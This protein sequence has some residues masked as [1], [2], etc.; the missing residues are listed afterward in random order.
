[1]R[2]LSH[3]RVL[4]SDRFTSLRSALVRVALSSRQLFFSL[5]LSLSRVDVKSS[6]RER[7]SFL[8]LKLSLSLDV[9]E[10]SCA[11]LNSHFYFP[12]HTLKR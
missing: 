5:S 3:T 1:M 11:F 4:R 12:A 10:E 6:R 9:N 2:T 8:F 7:Y